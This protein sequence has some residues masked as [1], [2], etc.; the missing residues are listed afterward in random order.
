MKKRN[1]IF[2]G[3][4]AILLTSCTV[5]RKVQYDKIVAN[6]EVQGTRSVAIAALDH[7]EHVIIN[8]KAPDFVGYLRSAVGIA[9]PIGTKS[10]KSLADDVASSI[11]ETLSKK[12]FKCSVFTTAQTDDEKVVV[13]KLI[14]SSSEISILFLMNAW[15]TDTYMP[16]LLT[17]DITVTIYDKN[18]IQLSTKKFTEKDKVIAKTMIWGNE[19][20]KFIPEAFKKE[21][22]IILNDPEIKKSLQ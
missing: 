13:E 15:W 14:A 1:L 4:I 6:V 11:S 21:L 20:E 3:L 17:Y 18:G 2:I 5:G 9:Y 7:R 16:T 22:E 10:K 8:G 12:G 19:Y